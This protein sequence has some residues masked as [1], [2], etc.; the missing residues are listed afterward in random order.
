MSGISTKQAT[1][2]ALLLTA[3]IV[4]GWAG[5]RYFVSAWP[6]PHATASPTR[7]QLL[8][9]S[10]G[11]V[12]SANTIVNSTPVAPNFIVQA[13]NRVGPAVV[14]L[15][16]SRRPNASA[17]DNFQFPGFFEDG[18]PPERFRQGSG[19]GFIVGADG[20]V[21]TNA[22]VVEGA[23]QVQVTLKDGRTFEGRVVGVDLVTDVAA[24]KIDSQDLPVVSLGDSDTLKPGQWAIAIGSPLGLDNTV[25]AGIISAT[26][27]PSNQ[28]GVG[29]RRVRFIQTD[30]AINP[31]NSGGPLLN[32][33]GEVIG[34]NTAIRANAQGLG[35]AI[36]IRT[37]QRIADQ[38]FATGT[39][40]HPYLGIQMVDLTPDI[41]KEVNE[42]GSLASKVELE[43]GVL[44]LDV[45]PQTPAAQA[46]LRPGDVILRVNGES[47][48]SS[49]NVQE[50]VEE[51]EIG[52]PLPIEV[53][54]NGVV[55]Q[56][57]VRPGTFPT[58]SQQR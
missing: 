56:V 54:R 58:Q 55:R 46:G 25:T 39:V 45:L 34:I 9:S 17:Q 50:Q 10:L 8:P 15:E 21:I 23:T 13:V 19:S 22:H 35:F 18:F 38:L 3:G 28:V 36:P 4:A 48:V 43:E 27:R 44:I 41:A 12:R 29:D 26:G 37:A 6:S 20:Q 14:R 33:Q 47:V 49:I 30:A 32:D 5:K 57:E 1:A 11:T 51:S 16:V 52:Q 7:L 40:D 53:N 31:G 2:Y 42:E 24:I